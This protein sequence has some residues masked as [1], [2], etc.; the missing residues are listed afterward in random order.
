MHVNIGSVATASLNVPTT[1]STQTWQA[2]NWTA[3]LAAGPQTLTLAFDTGGF[4][5]ASVV[6]ATP[7]APAGSTAPPHP[8]GPT[9]P[10]TPTP[11]PTGRITSHQGGD[12]QAAIN[13]ALPGDSILL[14]AGATF[15]GNFT[16]P[17]KTG[18]GYMSSAPTSPIRCRPAHASRPRPP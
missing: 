8:H 10:P 2:L 6:V 13:A 3:T 1:G 7:A 18:T 14:Q 16:L 9:V 12:L 5:V 4:S 11:S 17:A 15:T